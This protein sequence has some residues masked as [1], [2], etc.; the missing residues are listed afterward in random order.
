MDIPE[1][2]RSIPTRQSTATHELVFIAYLKPLFYKSFYIKKVTR[3][4]RDV[5]I[6][7]PNK[8][9]YDLEETINDYWKET[10]AKAGINYK[11]YLDD[12]EKIPLE[13]KRLKAADVTNIDL[14]VLR[15]KYD[16]NS[17]IIEDLEKIIEKERK[18]VERSKGDRRKDVKEYPNLNDEEMRMLS[19]E[20]LV[21]ERLEDFFVIEN[22]VSTNHAVP[23]VSPAITGTVFSEIIRVFAIF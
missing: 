17:K 12:E 23:A 10:I 9:T 22:G 20:P 4:K 11:N 2:V 16:P 7:K 8:R 5:T 15:D 14:D 13:P 18:G 6:Y 21:V 19:D 1:Q 3:T